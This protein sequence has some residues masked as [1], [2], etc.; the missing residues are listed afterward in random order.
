[1]KKLFWLAALGLA[2]GLNAAPSVAKKGIVVTEKCVIA[3]HFTECPL[4]VNAGDEP[5]V[6]YVPDEVRYYTLDLT[7]VERSRVD[8][9][10]ARSGNELEG[11]LDKKGNTLTVTS[12]KAPAPKKTVL[13][14]GCL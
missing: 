6:I 13:F 3:G 5:L 2:V 9:G 4:S 7:H 1:M 12:F 8:A 14:K 11:T 10:F